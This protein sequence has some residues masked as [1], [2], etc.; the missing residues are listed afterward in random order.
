M[1]VGRN[2]QARGR[3]LRECL[4]ELVAGARLDARGRRAHPACHLFGTVPDCV[5]DTFLTGFHPCSEV[6]G[7]ESA[8][9]IQSYILTC[10]RYRPLAPNK[11]SAASG[12]RRPSRPARIA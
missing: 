8:P 1:G 11:C 12:G 2:Y 6:K 9:A 7:H 3:L 5:R 4:A 10:D